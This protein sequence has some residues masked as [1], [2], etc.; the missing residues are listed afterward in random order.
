MGT[1]GEA[2]GDAL[3]L[4]GVRRTTD[5]TG[6]EEPA[7]PAP[8]VGEAGPSDGGEAGPP[9]EG[10]AGTGAVSAAAL[11]T[12]A[13][14]GAAFLSARSVLIQ[15]VQV[16]SSV[17]LARELVPE[18]YGAFALGA[19]LV[20][21][22]RIVG[23]CGAGNA[24]IQA[25]GDRQLNRPALQA[26]YFL[27][28]AVF[29]GAALILAV[30]A[31]GLRNLFD[32]PPETVP[33]VY[34]MALALLIEAP[35]VVP[36]LRLMRDLK[37]KQLASISVVASLSLY[38][39]QILGL[40]FGFGVW[41]L[42]IGQV[43]MSVVSTGLTLAVG[44][45]TPR[46][47]PRGS[48][49]PL[50]QRHR[51]PGHVDRHGLPTLPSVA[52]V[53]AIGGA[54]V[55][56]L[57]TWSTVLVTPLVT[58]V[59]NVHEIA[60]P[61]L[62]RLHEHQRRPPRR[63]R[64]AGGPLVVAGR[65]GRRRHPGRLRPAHRAHRVRPPLDPRRRRRP[66]RPVRGDRLLAHR[67]A[68]R[69]RAVHRP[70][71]GPPRPT[72]WA[73]AWAWPCWYPWSSCG[74]PR[75]RPWPPAWSQVV[76]LAILLVVAR[77]PLYR[78]FFNLAVVTTATF[79]WSLLL[80]GRVESFGGLVVAGIVAALPAALLVLVTDRRALAQSLSFLQA[81]QPGPRPRRLTRRLS[82]RPGAGSGRG[83]WGRRAGTWLRWRPRSGRRAASVR[84]P[85]AGPQ[86]LGHQP[87][88]VPRHHAGLTPGRRPP[89]LEVGRH[90]HRLAHRAPLHHRLHPGREPHRAELGL[91][92]QA[93]ST[94]RPA[95]RSPSGPHRSTPAFTATR[96]NPRSGG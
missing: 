49:H 73:P 50:P 20:G 88:G 8:E 39:A 12:S 37:F 55:L 31:P 6:A 89:A 96:S 81:P 45:G 10:E 27:Q 71:R 9:D 17:L 42:V 78:A 47:S 77:L 59:Q 72:W 93:G 83:A 2:G 92:G 29:L 74:V 63:R 34:V 26:V 5:A 79:T 15:L 11:G 95:S 52:I 56:G 80:A 28:L 36:R 75:G 4:P 84:P 69:R 30:S 51:L 76:D 54:D 3:A 43:V 68:G 82:G 65:G 46:P 7:T 86:P 60:F 32:G 61:T 14:R 64:G 25:S 58:M 67:A 33:I 90:R 48:L 62:A 1:A 21:F 66:G 13:A 53:G 19:T 22:G 70:A 35:A 44:G 18:L 94:G 91:V 57:W 87:P 38:T 16:V 85:L 23:D 24:I 41:A 40:V